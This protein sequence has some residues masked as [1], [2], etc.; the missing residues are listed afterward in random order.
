M[1]RIMAEHYSP[2][3]GPAGRSSNRPA[4]NGTPRAA[5]GRINLEALKKSVK[6]DHQERIREQNWAGALEKL[7]RL[8]SAGQNEN[9]RL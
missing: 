3:A 7:N 6:P 1:R 8:K 9:E 4:A 5:G 2:D